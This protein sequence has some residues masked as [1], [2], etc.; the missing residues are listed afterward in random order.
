[1]ARPFHLAVLAACVAATATVVAARTPVWD[2]DVWWVAAA[3]R[4][5]LAHGTVPRANVFSYVE[6]SHPWLMHE[7]LLGPVYA[8]VLA[9]F[10]PA[11]FDAVA[12]F[13]LACALGLLA[14]AT[15]GRARNLAVGLGAM[16]VAVTFF[17]GRFLSARPTGI[18]LLFPLAL[19]V[20]AFGHRFRPAAIALAG[21]IELVW[22]NAHGS[23]PLGILL[24]LVAAIDAES[25][26]L[27]RL[28]AAG[29]ATLAT[30]ATPYGFALHRFVW[31]YLRGNEG[32]YRAI[33]LHIR[34]FGT[35]REAWGATVGPVDL[36]GLALVCLLAAGAV[37]HARH[38]ARAF[39]CLGLTALA[40]LHARNLE[41]AGLLSCVLLVPYAD[42]LADRAS[43]RAAAAAPSL[44]ALPAQ[45]RRGAFAALVLLPAYV[46]GPIAFVDACHRREAGEWLAP[47]PSFLSLLSS[48]PD[49]SNVVAPFQTAGV[50]IWFGAPRGVRVFFDSRNDCYSVET[51]TS[52]WQLEASDTRAEQRRAILDASATDAALVPAVHPLASF[53]SSEAGWHLVREEGG[54]ALYRRASGPGQVGGQAPGV[55]QAP[56]S[57]ALAAASRSSWR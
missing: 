34:E 42:D 8:T 19:A 28:V 16:L 36:V 51:F 46:A 21:A 20:L 11:G 14:I 25:D 49:G 5:M 30:L 47:G 17:G 4:W 41:L 38:R 50:A 24:L 32:V 55:N 13:A 23:F 29:C 54:W 3:G 31:S 18:A 39:F 44:P 10:G 27:P 43:A 1:M 48:V 57:P 53:L 37:R 6:P 40:A 35:M 15:L 7:W 33:H 26:R 9:R 56:C 45:A 12:S 52:F 22:A 2:P